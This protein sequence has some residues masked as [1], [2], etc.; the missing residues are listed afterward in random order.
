MGKKDVSYLTWN[1][2]LLAS[3]VAT[4]IT[5]ISFPAIIVGILAVIELIILFIIFFNMGNENVRKSVEKEF[6]DK[7]WKCLTECFMVFSAFYFGFNKIGC[8]WLMT[9]LLGFSI[10]K[11]AKNHNA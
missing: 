7:W 5:K 4:D 10:S 2:F 8:A 11:I 3:I 9:F 6:L 1:L